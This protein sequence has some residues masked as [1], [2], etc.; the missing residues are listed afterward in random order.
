MSILIT[1]L[2]TAVPHHRI[3]Q[4]DAA[5]ISKRFS[6]ETAAQERLFQTLYRRTGVDGRNCVVL[7]RS[8][9]T[10]NDRQSFY[11]SSDPTTLDRMRKYEEQAGSLALAACKTALR[12]AICEP[13]CITHLV[14]ISCTG[15]FAPGFD[16]ELVKQLPLPA[17]VARTQIGFMGCQGALNG[18]RVARAFLEADPSAC[19]LLCALE[20]C[21]LHHQYG[22]DADKI[23]ANALF[24]DGAAA[25]IA[26]SDQ[27]ARP[28]RYRLLASGS[29][30][31]QNSAEA[32]SWRIGNQ[33]FEMSLSARVPDLICQYLRPWLES[34][35]ADHRLALCD[36]PSWAVHPGGPRILSA[37]AE[38]LD[39]DRHALEA[40]QQVLADHGNMS[41]PTILFILDR[42][43]TAGAAGPCVSLAFGPGLSI[44]A[45]LLA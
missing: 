27:S 28:H 5:E 26:T 35:L 19:V 14:T 41:S 15:F 30:V 20:L 39:L 3:S 34:W 25:V 12:D 9:G 18:L 40:S 44:E 16:I 11:S 1:G 42:L 37:V 2:G 29:T 23:V 6:C 13:D 32:M 8:E 36:I 24:S 31:V 10:L 22:W 7:D 17:R 33:G 4:V 45:A 43:C 38:A 21:S